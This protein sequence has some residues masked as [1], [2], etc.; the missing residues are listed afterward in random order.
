MSQAEDTPQRA[1]S[2]LP[3]SDQSFLEWLAA[4]D[5]LPF[6]S[7]ASVLTG[8]WLL[9][10]SFGRQSWLEGKLLLDLITQVY[11]FSLI[12]GVALMVRAGRWRPAAILALLESLFLLDCAFNTEVMPQLEGYAWFASVVWF[13][14]VA[15][16]IQMLARALRLQGAPAVRRLP[17]LMA[18]LIWL[19]P[20]VID[21]VGRD[22][23]GLWHV[24]ATWAV[25]V[26]L[27]LLARRTPAIQT[28]LDQAK[29]PPA[30]L[31]KLWRGAIL[32]WFALLVSHLVSWMTIYSIE[33]SKAHMLA[34]AA[35]VFIVARRPTVLWLA[36]IGVCWQAVAAQ[37]VAPAWAYAILVAIVIWRAVEL[38]RPSLLMPVVLTPIWAL[39][40]F[41]TLT[42]SSLG[43]L[44]IIAGFLALAMSVWIQTR[45][46]HAAPS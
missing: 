41:P 23:A 31:D 3:A 4:H 30:T 5:P 9:S 24:G 10:G 14:L 34:I 17:L 44:L 29:C 11:E 46:G 20:Q 15:V 1:P 37:E 32:I 8:I 25:A 28:G 18:S 33:F 39:D 26:L 7:A 21:D 36:L 16:K 45:T 42:R 38:R 27:A 12:L 13:L 6:L 35:S 43:T 22:T 2:F 40:L 19:V